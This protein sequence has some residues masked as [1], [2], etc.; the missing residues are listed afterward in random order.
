MLIIILLMAALAG[1]IFIF[2]HWRRVHRMLNRGERYAVEHPL[3]DV[4]LVAVAVAGYVLTRTVI[5]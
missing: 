5:Y 4:C 3:L 1:S 2:S